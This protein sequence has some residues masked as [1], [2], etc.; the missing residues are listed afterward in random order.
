MSLAHFRG[1]LA[2]GR[3][4]ERR[5]PLPR[6]GQGR[7]LDRARQWLGSGT[8]DPVLVGVVALGVYALHGYQGVLERDLGVFTYGG[9]HVTRGIAPYV[10]I[11]NSVG[12]LADAVPG[13]AMWLGHFLGLDPV[14]S[15]RLFFTILSALCC[16]GLC[17]LARDLF[18]SRAAGFV[19]PAIFLTFEE[20]LE[21][22]SD[23]PR[24]KTTMVLLL[25]V[26]L[27]LLGRR[28]WLTAGMCAA[29]AT[30]TWQPV[31]APAVAAALAAAFLEKQGRLRALLRFVAGGGLVTL[32]AVVVFA[33]AGALR[34]AVGGFVVVNVLYTHQP[35]AFSSPRQTWRILWSAYHL[36]LLVAIAGLVALTV[37]AVRAIPVARRSRLGGSAAPR[38][39]VVTGTAGAA[40]TAWT[41]AV[42]NGG[43]DLFVVLPFGALGAA[44]IVLLVAAH[45]PRR[46]GVLVT[47]AVVVAGVALGGVVAVRSRNDALVQQSA[48][49]RA[50]L[51]TQ[52][53]GA[54]VLSVDAPQVL[55]IAGRDNPTPYQLFGLRMDRYLD[56]SYPGG[57]K[58]F[59]TRMR[60]LRPTF[61][62]V[63]E[64]VRGTFPHGMLARY[65]WLVGHGTD[66]NWYLSRTAGTDAL[67]RATSANRFAMF[68]HPASPT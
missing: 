66:W 60:H 50:V 47:A 19:A 36:S 67:Q 1:V 37:L 12:P 40:A 6:A 16:A 17:V 31:L 7:P 44:A 45:V 24:E 49:V 65:Y 10:G 68:T 20:F 13:L 11:F 63:G 46:A 64:N 22:A 38:R 41:L 14:F 2:N 58:E 32:A 23:G 21:L 4:V 61:V 51:A 43:P 15:A 18:G 27:I 3:P 28:R 48:D 33:L 5:L 26:T 8:L 42:V 25:V 35:S 29:L 59:A 30:L 39:L 57:M 53:P 52:P 9:E 55:A 34:A 62:V 54:T 56:H